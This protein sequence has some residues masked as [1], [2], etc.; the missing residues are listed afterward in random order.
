METD[1]LLVVERIQFTNCLTCKKH[2]AA[3]KVRN[4]LRSE[5]LALSFLVVHMFILP[6]AIVL[7]EENVFVAFS[8]CLFCHLASYCIN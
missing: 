5:F 8:D 1:I 2:W 7:N 4:S 3:F 6:K